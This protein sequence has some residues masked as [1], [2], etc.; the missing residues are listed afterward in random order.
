MSIENNLIL[1][2][3]DTFASQPFAG[4][5]AAVCLIDYPLNENLMQKIAMEVNLSET[6]FLRP[7]GEYSIHK[8]R[9]FKTHWFSP[10]RELNSAGHSALA[11][12]CVL[13]SI[14][15]SLSGTIVLEGVNNSCVVRSLLNCFQIWYN[16][17]EP[18]PYRLPEIF[19]NALRLDRDR[20]ADDFK[21]ACICPRTRMLLIRFGSAESIE[22]IKPDFGDLGHAQESAGFDAVIVT[23]K[24]SHKY[25]FIS[26][27]F[28]P[29]IGISE[30]SVSA[31]SHR[32][33]VP[34][35]SALLG[36]NRFTAFQASRRGGELALELRKRSR[37]KPDKV[38]VSGQ[39]VITLQA[40]IDLENYHE[41]T[42]NEENLESVH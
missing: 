23:A 16:V 26:R 38:V 21:E 22:K 25:D 30:D 4:N 5:P 3:V 39:A 12:A 17:A 40:T 9:R 2:Q 15:N 11:S 13:K 42:Q 28:A 7:T 6:A 14:Y 31:Q 10:E 32:I 24:G 27:T 36:K 8:C 20:L 41:N 29:A 37:N 33:L 1:F 34:Y 19:F 18:E 35:W